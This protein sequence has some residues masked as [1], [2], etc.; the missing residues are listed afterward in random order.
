MP[1]YRR[2]AWVL[3]EPQ[4]WKEAGLK[5]AS[6]FRW[7]GSGGQ[8]LVMAATC[9]SLLEDGHHDSSPGV[10]CRVYAL[11]CLGF[12]W[13]SKPLVDYA[14]YTLWE[15]QIAGAAGGRVRRGWNS[16]KWVG[17][18]VID[19]RHGLM[20][21]CRDI[22]VHVCVCVEAKG[23]VES[24]PCWV[25]GCHRVRMYSSTCAMHTFGSPPASASPC[26]TCQR[27]G[28]RPLG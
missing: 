11:D 17:V 6:C 14:S 1:G 23:W 20:C 5:A 15:E 10:R 19:A 24:T 2:T 21:V 12:G 27:L 8:G 25:M 7:R 26:W 22:C 28:P 16:L 18:F 9:H 3:H 13:S 4:G